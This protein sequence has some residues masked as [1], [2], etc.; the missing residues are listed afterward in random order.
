MNNETSNLILAMKPYLINRLYLLAAG[1]LLG[2]T[3]H[4][5]DPRTNSW[6]T[7]YSAKYARIYTT[8]ANKSSGTSVT[9]WSNGTQTQSL[10]A[11]AGV[12][13]L[14]SSPSWVYLRSTAGVRGM[15]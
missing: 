5:A 6:L 14:Y 1:V 7:S 10:P 11:Y 4:A 8:D 3:L 9:T 2:G 13:E 15:R 12:Q